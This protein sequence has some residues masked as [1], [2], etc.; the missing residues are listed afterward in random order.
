MSSIDTYK[1]INQ[2]SE[3]VYKEK[4]SKFFSHAIPV[5]DEEHIKLNLEGLKKRF[6]DAHHHCFAYQVGID[7]LKY[8]YSDDGEPS[9][10]AGRPIFGQIQSLGLTNILIVVV[11]YFGGTRLGTGG[12]INAYRSAARRALDHAGIVEKEVREIYELQFDYQTL[13]EVMKVLKDFRTQ[14]LSHNFQERCSM[15]A[16]IG[17]RDR[18]NVLGFL[19]KLRGLTYS[20][21]ATV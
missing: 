3:G 2:I 10:T 8:R 15:V 9:G 20:Y 11:R 13:N 19:G 12:L 6:H 4:G 5:A 17:R 16:S 14:Q 21:R 1:T 7:T 18:E